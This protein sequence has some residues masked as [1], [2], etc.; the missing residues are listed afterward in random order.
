M[1]DEAPRQLSRP[2]EG[3]CFQLTTDPMTEH[4]GGMR[5]FELTFE[6]PEM[7]EEIED[8][9][10]ED[11][12]AVIAVHSGVTTVTVLFSAADCITAARTAI[13]AL[14][15]LGAAPIRLVDDLV[16][17]GQIAERAGVTR[18]AV[19]LWVRGERHSEDAFPA[20]FVPTGGGLWLWGEV[21]DALAARGIVLDEGVEY[22]TRRDAQIVGGMLAAHE[23][24]STGSFAASIWLAAAPANA[25]FAV[26]A[27][28]AHDV[29]PVA[30]PDSF[31]TNFALGA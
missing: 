13:D 27:G 30:A 17:R 25:H 2:G 31:R 6:V 24:T 16:T 9:V 10:A 29:R 12:D 15:R 21:V 14:T 26:T 18:Q 7:A 8:A 19:G 11:L 28:R 23:A 3:F 4:R 20:P 5:Q 22:P 1:A